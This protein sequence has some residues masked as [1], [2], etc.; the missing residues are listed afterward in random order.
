MKH[1]TVNINTRTH[2]VPYGGTWSL[3][4]DSDDILIARE[5]ST[6]ASSE[7]TKRGIRLNFGCAIPEYLEPG[8]YTIE[9]EV[10]LGGKVYTSTE[11][12]IVAETE[13]YDDGVIITLKPVFSWNPPASGT[14]EITYHNKVVGRSRV[15]QH[16][17][18]KL[19]IRLPKAQL[20]PAHLILLSNGSYISYRVYYINSS[21]LSAVEEIKKMLDRL[22]MQLRMDSLKFTDGD[23]LDWLEHGR[24]HFNSLG[25][26]TDFNMSQATGGIRNY[27]LLC[28]CWYALRTRYLEEGLTSFS[29]GGSAVTLDIDVTNFIESQISAMESQ[30]DTLISF[31]EQLSINSIRGGDGIHTINRRGIGATGISLGPSTGGYGI[32]TRLW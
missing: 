5:T 16:K 17:P 8:A 27:W 3:F 11:P 24:A 20:E 18:N 19:A 30:F 13:Q 1:I 7:Q 26:Q 32:H 25:H 29:Y 6:L 2:E 21:I 12:Y 9:M 14:V 4:R 28:S 15:K 23:Y 10:E 31:K 22:N